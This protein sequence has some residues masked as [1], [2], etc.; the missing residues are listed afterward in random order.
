MVYQS[1]DPSF[2]GPFTSE[3]TDF[4]KYFQETIIEDLK[5]LVFIPGIFHTHGHHGMEVALIQ[6]LLTLSVITDAS[7][8]E[9][10]FRQNLQIGMLLV[11]DGNLLPYLI[12][13]FTIHLW[14]IKIPILEYPVTVFSTLL[15]FKIE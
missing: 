12:H 11:N 1:P 4:L 10:G 3:G 9:F 15:Y 7:L 14:H 6:L 13:K 2:K 8:Y 5:C